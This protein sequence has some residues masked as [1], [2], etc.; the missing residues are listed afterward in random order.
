MLEG[1]HILSGISGYDAAEMTDE[2]PA[3][4]EAVAR[5]TLTYLSTPLTGRPG[6]DGYERGAARCAEP[7]RILARSR[8]S[9][10]MRA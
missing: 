1:E 9:K 8:R 6:V 4:V 5:L 7:A 10:E 2:S 3:R